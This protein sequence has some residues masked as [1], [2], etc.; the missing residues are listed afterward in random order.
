VGFATKP[1]I[2][3]DQ[4]RDA[5]A[6]DL[7]PGVVLA[8]AAYGS[9]MGFRLGVTGLGLSYAVGVMAT[10][11]VW[12]PGTGP[13]GPAPSR[14]G[15]GRPSTRLRR[16]ADHQPVS[17][18]ELAL[19]LADEAWREVTWREGTNETL[20]SRFA[21]LRVRPAHRDWKR[22]QPWPEEWLLIEWPEGEAEPTKYWLSTLAED[23]AFAEMVR[24]TKLRWRIERD[25]RDLKQEVGLGHYEGRGWRGF[26]HHASLCI[27]AYGFLVRERILFSPSGGRGKTWIEKSALPDG[28]RPRGAP[29]PDPTP[30][31]H[32]HRDPQNPD[33][34]PSRQENT[35]M[36]VL[37]PDHS[38]S[39]IR[40]GAFVTQ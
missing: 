33:R 7:P 25:Y 9:D 26:H 14:A 22:Q 37:P 4:I 11:T 31:A 6:R 39:R 17:V 19:S 18:K 29:N 12:G 15:V 3:L 28:F 38:G 35:K 23:L 5:V 21:R 40:I 2:A 1:E 36:S 13:L 32:V 8:D 20:R 10:T 34:R 30:R 24:L 27:A 16:D